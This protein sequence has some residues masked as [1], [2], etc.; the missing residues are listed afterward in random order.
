MAH[1]EL[2]VSQWAKLAYYLGRGAGEDRYRALGITGAQVGILS[3]LKNGPSPSAADLARDMFLSPQAILLLLNQLEANGFVVRASDRHHG[4]IR[5]VHLT[6][7][8]RDIL[9]KAEICSAEVEDLL[10]Q[11]FTP[12]ERR[13]FLQ[14]LERYV[15]WVKEHPWTRPDEATNEEPHHAPRHSTAL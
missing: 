13:Q 11:P 10:L 4:R 12:A 8:G 5:R 7:A 1:T 15:S 6:N 2:R 14:F 9:A 3:R